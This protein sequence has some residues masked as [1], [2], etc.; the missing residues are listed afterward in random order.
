MN[1]FTWLSIGRQ[2]LECAVHLV[3]GE[4]CT[5]T[6]TWHGQQYTVCVTHSPA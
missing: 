6:F 3:A 1:W 2:L 4:K 5:F